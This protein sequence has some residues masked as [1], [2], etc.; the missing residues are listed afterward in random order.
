MTEKAPNYS[1]ADVARLTEM[2]DPSANAEAR[3]EVVGSLALELGKTK[4]SIVAKLVNLGIYVSKDK[5]AP[6]KSIARKADM[7]AL[8]ANLIGA[9]EDVIGSLEK[10]TKPAL[11]LVIE[12]LD[13]Q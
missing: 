13:P 6:G 1:V 3:N 11:W 2:Y 10:A 5:A 4:A 7:V 8:I 9:D 12:A